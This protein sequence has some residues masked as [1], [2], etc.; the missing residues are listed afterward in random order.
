MPLE[1][2]LVRQLLLRAPEALEKQHFYVL[3]QLKVFPKRETCRLKIIWFS[4]LFS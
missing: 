4:R 1:T 2:E 3:A